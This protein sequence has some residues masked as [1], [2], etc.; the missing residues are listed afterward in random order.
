MSWRTLRSAYVLLAHDEPRQSGWLGGSSPAMHDPAL[1][2]QGRV[3][4]PSRFRREM[5][6]SGRA[7]TP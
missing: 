7:W 5:Y 6:V 3:C 1:L 2:P 4:T